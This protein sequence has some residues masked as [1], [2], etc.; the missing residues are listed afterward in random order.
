MLPSE[1]ALGQLIKYNN[2]QATVVGVLR[3]FINNTLKEEI[4]P[5]YFYYG[6]GLRK[7][8]IKMA[9]TNIS[10]ALPTIQKMWENLYT[11]A[12]FHYEF[13]DDYIAILY[14]LE[15]TL[16]RFFRIMAGLALVIGC[17]GLYGLVS[18][19]AL[20]RQKE[21]GIRK[22][23]GATVQQIL[24]RFTKE[25]TG[26]VLLAFVV[27]A[28]LAYFAM[29]FWLNTFAYR[30]DLHAGYFIITLVAALAIA[31]FT[32]GFQSIRAAVANP[33]DSLRNE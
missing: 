27:A 4:H 26:L 29:R 28:P 15:D 19:L 14:T 32:V 21:I 10:Q 22:T 23:L 30:I 9:S 18:F 33:V 5:T 1:E 3:D 13:M 6:D 12:F 7:A 31:C 25:F 8:T 20:H 24:Y 11:E 17:L 16:Y 2:Q